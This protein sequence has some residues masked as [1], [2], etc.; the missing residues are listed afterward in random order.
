M[1]FATTWLNPKDYHGHATR[2]WKDVLLDIKEGR[3]TTLK[4]V[5]YIYKVSRKTEELILKELA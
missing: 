2:Q 3:I 5:T 4:Q 1:K